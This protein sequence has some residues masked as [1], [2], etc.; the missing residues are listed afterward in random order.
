MSS[1]TMGLRTMRFATAAVLALGMLVAGHAA[2]AEGITDY[3]VSTGIICETPQQ[4]ERFIS[5]FD[6][7][8]SARAI[9]AVNAEAHD[10]AACSVASLAFVR[11]NEAGTIHRGD[12]AYTIV[13][14]LVLG[15][16]TDEGIR[17]IVPSAFFTVFTVTEY[18]I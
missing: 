15:I 11:G 13:H 12:S 7:A 2:R 9:K 17:P 3:E 14:I 18:G 5:L 6:G 1:A 8:D 10:P 16:A 4:V